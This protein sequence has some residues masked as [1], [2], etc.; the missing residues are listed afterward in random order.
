MIVNLLTADEQDMVAG[1]SGWSG[2]TNVESLTRS[3]T[4]YRT[5]PASMLVR[6]T[7]VNGATMTVRLDR[8]IPVTPGTTYR[9]F[10][11]ARN[12]TPGSSVGVQ[13]L[14]YDAAGTVSGTP[15]NSPSTQYRE[16]ATVLFNRW[17][18]VISEFTAPSGAVSAKVQL[19][20]EAVDGGTWFDVI[21]LVEWPARPGGGFANLLLGRTIPRYMLDADDELTDPDH[22]L[23]RYLDLVTFNGD[24]IMETVKAFDYIPSV[25]GVPGYDRC[26][27]V[28]PEYYPQDNVAEPNWLPW[29]A[30]LVGI[31]PVYPDSGGAQT[32]WFYFEDTY[33]SWNSW[34]TIDATT[35]PAFPLTSLTRTSNT[36]TAVYGAQSAGPTYTPTVGD[37]VEVTGIAGFNGA[38]VLLTVNTG[39]STVTWSD[40]AANA[41]ASSGTM[42][43]SDLSWSEAEAVN[44]TAFDSLSTLKHLTRTTASGVRVGSE[45][46]IIDAARAVLNG[47]DVKGTA[48]R[49]S[50]VIT[51]TTT[52]PHTLSASGYV[53]LC[54]S[55]IPTLNI[56]GTVATVVDPNTFTVSSVGPD[57]GEATIYAT[58]KEVTLTE[59]TAWEWELSTKLDQ[60][61]ASDLLENIV[62]ATKPAG[63]LMTFTTT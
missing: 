59:T 48:S 51:V 43:F 53:R 10:C 41:T 61:F 49:Q 24:H 34:Q 25:D 13:A 33:P 36:V 9:V 57:T 32:P 18:T 2:I 6:P 58:N 35:N 50:D 38:F 3:T 1:I 63:V 21:G 12:D 15:I 44:P 40:T 5:E 31:K 14:V 42:T 37:P 56:V 47:I 22:P 8:Y 54:E 4:T 28:Q 46:A 52:A 7:T 11:S 45:S 26:T 16:S 27:L 23:A 30:Q 55:A 19:D 17:V 60:T 62:K 29:V 39:T 20:S